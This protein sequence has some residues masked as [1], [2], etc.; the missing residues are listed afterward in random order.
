MNGAI[1][2]SLPK[3]P[4]GEP[5][6][7]SPLSA[8]SS[9]FLIEN[10]LNLPV[11]SNSKPQ[12]VAADRLVSANDVGA[13]HDERPLRSGSAKCRE[14]TTKLGSNQFG[15][16]STITATTGDTTKVQQQQQQRPRKRRPR[17]KRRD[18]SSC[19]SSGGE[20]TTTN[21]AT[22]TTRQ[23]TMFSEWQLAN[24][25]WRFARNK[26]LTTSDRIRVADLLQLNQLQVKTWF[27]VSLS[28]SK[29]ATTIVIP[30]QQANYCQSVVRLVV[31]DFVRS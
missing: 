28:A 12:I 6:S 26:Y 4:F 25:E 18:S 29:H 31:H 24:L 19:C 2:L 23:R 20:L 9:K 8:K 3:A 1:D 27:Q 7:W 21:L 10:I 15:K 11:L 30:S 5:L 13:N 14:T 22:T 17:R 16:A